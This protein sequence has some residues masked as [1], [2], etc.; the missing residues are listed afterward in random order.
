MIKLIYLLI[1]IIRVTFSELL[2]LSDGVEV[3]GMVGWISAT[4]HKLK[5]LRII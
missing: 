4:V 1:I 5:E 2:V 3:K